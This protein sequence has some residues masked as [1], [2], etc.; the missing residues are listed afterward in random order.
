MSAGVGVVVTNQGGTREI[1]RHGENGFL[2]APDDVAGMVDTIAGLL[3]DSS[4]LTRV[5]EAARRTAVEEFPLA[6][7]VDRYLE[8]YEEALR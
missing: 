6:K 8:I 7:A 5:E 2:H 3:E 1:V 4:R